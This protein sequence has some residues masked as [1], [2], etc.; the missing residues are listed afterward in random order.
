MSHEPTDWA[1][2]RRQKLQDLLGLG[3]PAHPTTFHT[4]H[5]ARE[6]HERFDELEGA[7]LTVA[8]RIMADNRMG[9]AAFLRLQDATGRIQLYVK[10]DVVGEELWQYYRLLDRGDLVGATGP[11]FRTKTGEA[12]VE[13]RNL[14][15]LQKSYAPLPEKFHGLQDVELR[16]RRRYLDLIANEE[17]RTIAVRRARMIGAIREHLHGLGFLEVE[18][19]V[20]QP[21]YGG[22]AA[23]PFVTHVD[24]FDM[25]VYLRIA[26]ELYLKRLL[27]GGLERVY[28]IG[29]D[30]RNEGFSRKHSQ[31]FTMLELYQAYADYHDMARLME[32]MVSRLAVTLMGGTVASFDGQDVETAVPWQ[33]T[34]FREAMQ[35]L[36]K[37]NVTPDTG[38][39]E[40]LEHG[41]RHGVVV[42]DAM[43]RGVLLDQIWST[44]VEPRLIQPTLVMDYPIDFP[45]STFARSGKN[46]GEVERFEAFAG[47]MELANAFSEV[48]DRFEQEERLRMLAAQSGTKYDPDEV[49]QDFLTALQYGMPPAGGLGIGLDR[50]AMV[51]TGADHIRETILFPLLRRAE[52][53]EC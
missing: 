51:L 1:A 26:D 21:L 14:V 22:G 52:D 11:L 41:K 13:V 33:R 7:T 40:L 19:P 27:V 32:E 48:N 45:G 31:E 10:R 42:S 38:A 12:T 20:L 35:E 9:K 2:Q 29:K 4:S 46:P 15:L 28:E 18:T 39:A 25:R 23:T 49:D 17:S 34:T 53:A 37:L 8:G 3:L 5:S 16:Y 30:F 44:M 24:A 6:L 50:L 36:A 43:S 47:G